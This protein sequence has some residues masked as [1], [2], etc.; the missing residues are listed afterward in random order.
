[1]ANYYGKIRTNYFK[2]TDENKFIENIGCLTGEDDVVCYEHYE[3]KGK[4]MFCCDGSLTGYVEDKSDEDAYDDAWDEMVRKLQTVLP[5]GEA[6]I[7]MEIGSEKMRYFTAYASIITANKT[8]WA[9]L[10]ILAMEEAGRLL[11]DS[12]YQTQMEY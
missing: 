9:D 8:G 5:E 3:D 1:M 7:L 2:V 11:G 12:D 4:F 10:T 6:I